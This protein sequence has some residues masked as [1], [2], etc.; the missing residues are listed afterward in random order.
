MT[1]EPSYI[2]DSPAGPEDADEGPRLSDGDCR[3]VW[4]STTDNPPYQ[5]PRYQG[6]TYR[7]PLNVLV[8]R[9]TVFSGR[10]YGGLSV[11]RPKNSYELCGKQTPAL[12]DPVA[13]KGRL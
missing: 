4:N 9:A 13:V 3:T 1:D 6:P 2:T 8:G 10:R 12:F 7:R 11:A 5:V